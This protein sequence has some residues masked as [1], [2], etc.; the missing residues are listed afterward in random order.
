MKQCI[1]TWHTLRT[2]AII[3]LLYHQ[4]LKPRPYIPFCCPL[5]IYKREW[6]DLRINKFAYFYLP[7]IVKTT[8]QYAYC[9][10]RCNTNANKTNWFK[11]HYCSRLLAKS[12]NKYWSMVTTNM[13]KN[14]PIMMNFKTFAASLVIPSLCRCSFLGFILLQWTHKGFLFL[15]RLE[16]SMTKLAWSIDEL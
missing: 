1:S 6:S 3:L 2:C 4:V 16:T 14:V 15:T 8:C 11:W 9:T 13:I 5:F 10:T 7:V 12:H